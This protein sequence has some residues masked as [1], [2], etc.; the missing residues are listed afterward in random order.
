MCSN[1]LKHIE[2]A[3]ANFAGKCFGVE[4]TSRQKIHHSRRQ[5]VFALNQSEQF[6]LWQRERQERSADA[7]KY[8]DNWDV[9]LDMIND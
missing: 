4:P 6:D 8:W 3:L 2:P 7:W 1:V 5:Q 9:L